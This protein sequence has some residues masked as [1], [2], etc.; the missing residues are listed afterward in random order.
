M[1]TNGLAAAKGD[2]CAL[3]PP[4]GIDARALATS[5]GGQKADTLQG[6]ITLAYG[7]DCWTLGGSSS[8]APGTTVELTVAF[9]GK[10]KLGI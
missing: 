5:G 3:M 1:A 2:Y 10:R 8:V 4:S 6:K 7:A 9:T